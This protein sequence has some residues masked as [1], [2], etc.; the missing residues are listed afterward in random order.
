[1]TKIVIR[2]ALEKRLRADDSHNPLVKEIIQLLD[3][4]QKKPVR[5]AGLSYQEVVRLFRGELGS[6]LALPPNPSAG[7][8]VR[9][10]TRARD[11]G[12]SEENVG[13]IC[14]GLRRLYPRGPYNLDFVVNSISRAFSVGANTEG[15]EGSRGA[16]VVRTGRP[17][18]DDS[19]D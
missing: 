10:V 15:G 11:Q 14:T 5:S 19:E 3:D 8:I 16:A 7:Y 18:V 12:L 1:M 17:D 2:A 13:Q 4:A 9:V 6:N